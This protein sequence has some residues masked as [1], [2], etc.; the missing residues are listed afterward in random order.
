MHLHAPRRG[1]CPW[2]WPRGVRTSKQ[3]CFCNYVRTL[4]RVD[5]D[6]RVLH[7]H[8]LQLGLMN[9]GMVVMI[10][11]IDA[12][13]HAHLELVAD[14]NILPPSLA[15]PHCTLDASTAICRTCC[16]AHP[17]MYPADQALCGFKLRHLYRFSVHRY[18]YIATACRC[19]NYINYFN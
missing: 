2:P 9:V 17:Y 13:R 5:G 3:R 1:G 14:L 18:R 19:K 6:H 10:S 7:A 16:S 12:R 11:I 15:R 8:G 4:Q